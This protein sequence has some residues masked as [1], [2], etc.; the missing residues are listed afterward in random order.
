MIRKSSILTLV[1][2]FL[3]MSVYAVQEPTNTLQPT[4]LVIDYYYEQGQPI[5]FSHESFSLRV[6]SGA[7]VHDLAFHFAVVKDQ[8]AQ[9]MPSNMK[10]VTGEFESFNRRDDDKK[11]YLATN[12]RMFL[13]FFM[14]NTS[15][16]AWDLWL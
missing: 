11:C 3:S 7:L 12:K 15:V 13:C 2:S 14:R 8:Q 9:P 10:N 6:D 1:L 4:S 16:S 5:T